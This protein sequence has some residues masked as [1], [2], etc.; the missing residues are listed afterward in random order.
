MRFALPAF[1]VLAVIN[2]LFADMAYAVVAGT[3]R[4]PFSPVIVIII[5]AAARLLLPAV[6]GFWVYPLVAMGLLAVGALIPSSLAAWFVILGVS[7][8]GLIWDR[9]RLSA[10]QMML[11]LAMTQIWHGSAF[12]IFASSFTSGEALLLA[13]CLRVLGFIPEVDGNVVRVTADHAL[14]LLSGCS[15][16]AGLGVILLGWSAVFCLLRPNERFPGRYIGGVA[17]VAI[18]LN[19][20]RLIVMSYGPE[21]HEF[22]HNGTG[23]TLFDALV[24]LLVVSA[25]WFPARQAIIPIA[26]RDHVF[27]KFSAPIWTRNGVAVY[28]AFA[29]VLCVSLAIKAVRY[30]STD[31]TGWHEA[32]DRIKEDVLARGFTFDGMVSITA[33]HSI[34]G[35]AFK[36]PDC[37][38]TLL[39]AMIGASSDTLPMITRYMAGTH[40]GVYLDG[41]AVGR[42]AVPRFLAVNIAEIA[43]SAVQGRKPALHPLLAVSR[44]LENVTDGCQWPS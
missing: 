21:W 11:A 28:G 3:G 26:R 23:A 6:P 5:I 19:I 2:G 12:K 25:A 37:G 44:P 13:A 16:F 14:V 24:C 40:V 36:K 22:A 17:L 35:M 8:L 42:D 41:S 33:D 7:T 39:I 32:T 1:F 15:V 38:G 4:L 34:E 31:A 18:C 9:N 10:Y 43:I 20:S 29:L 27:G 30:S